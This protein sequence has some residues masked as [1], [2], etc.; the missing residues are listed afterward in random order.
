MTV[1]P[2]IKHTAAEETLFGLESQNDDVLGSLKI[3][4]LPTRRIESWH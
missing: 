4:G 1:V 2:M 3:S